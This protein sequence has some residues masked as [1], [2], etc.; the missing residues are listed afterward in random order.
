MCSAVWSI[1]RGE[2]ARIAVLTCLKKM[3]KMMIYRLNRR[4]F[5]TLLP[6]LLVLLL[7]LAMTSCHDDDDD[8]ET[9]TVKSHTLLMYMPWSGD[10]NALTSYFWGN[11]SDMKSACDKYGTDD[12]QVVVFI[13]TSGTEGYMFPIGDYKGYNS[14]ALASYQRISSPQLTSSDG[15]A[16]ILSSMM[17]MA[18]ARNYA[19]TIGCHGMG[20]LPPTATATVKKAASTVETFVPYWENA[21]SGGQITRY[22]GGTSAKY[23]TSTATLAEAIGLTGVK[24]DFILFDDCY[25]SSIEAAYDL[26]HAANFIIACPTEVMGKGMPYA[27]IG[28]YLLSTPDYDAVCKGFVSYYSSTSYPLGT[29]GV[30]DCEQLDSLANIVR[31]INSSNTFDTANRSNLQR[32]DGYTPAIFYDYGDYV[33]SLC[34][35]SALL[36]RFNA[37]LN[38]TIPYKGHTGWFPTMSRC[39]GSVYV[40]EGIWKV[41]INAYSGTTTSEPSVSSLVVDSYKATEWYKATH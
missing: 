5:S 23:Q 34:A 19:M 22:F 41:K 28:R 32:M 12:V 24:M 39:S 31:E 33:A 16:A 25:M 17:S 18:P 36:A 37:Q 9:S 2:T 26:R 6:V 15:I 4:L 10:K 21:V 20:W 38:R 13:C 11:I 40:D 30:T 27:T 7:P 3:K 8:S 29:I 1:E 35:D 14:T